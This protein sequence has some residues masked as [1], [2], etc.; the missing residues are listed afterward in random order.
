[1]D[2]K[3]K[4]NTTYY[5]IDLHDDWNDFDYRTKKNI[6]DQTDRYNFATA[7]WSYDLADLESRAYDILHILTCKEDEE[8]AAILFRQAERT[9]NQ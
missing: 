8:I 9:A 3:A 7:N 2:N 5:F 4:I 6:M 1:M